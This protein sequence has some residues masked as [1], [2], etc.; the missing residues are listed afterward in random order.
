VIADLDTATQHNAAL[1]EESTAASHSLATES[2]RLEQ[3]VG[4][5]SVSDGLSLQ[6]SARHVAS[7]ARAPAAS[8]PRPAPAPAAPVAP[9][10]PPR[11]ASVGNTALAQDDDWSEF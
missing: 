1:V 7:P 10:R 8:S 5:F 4:R 2:E 11:P 6:G 3:V 9:A